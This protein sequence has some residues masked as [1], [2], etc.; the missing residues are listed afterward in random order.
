[1]VQRGNIIH[2]G[3][4][5]FF[6][7]FSGDHCRLLDHLSDT[8]SPHVSCRERERQLLPAPLA[9]AVDVQGL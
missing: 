4:Q 2:L 6:F 5:S 9:R 1:M 7:F 3:V 8:R